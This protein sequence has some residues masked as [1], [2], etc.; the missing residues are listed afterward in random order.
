MVDFART[1]KPLSQRVP[2]LPD[3]QQHRPTESTASSYGHSLLDITKL[4]TPPPIL[5]HKTLQPSKHGYHP[6]SH[7]ATYKRLDRAREIIESRINQQVATLVAGSQ[8]RLQPDQKS[9]QDSEHSSE[10]TSNLN[11]I[12]NR[13]YTMVKIGSVTFSFK[14]DPLEQ[15]I[16]LED[17]L[18]ALPFNLDPTVYE[19]RL[20]VAMD[21]ATAKAESEKGSQQESGSGSE[22]SMLVAEVVQKQQEMQKVR[23]PR[24][25]RVISVMIP[26]MMEDCEDAGVS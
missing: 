12:S 18:P 5:N 4:S 24:G 21:A 10:L 13:D 2:S 3:I 26:S 15:G 11:S 1:D 9:E 16:P 17:P 19:S 14:K 6:R 8:N 23:S 20:K 7:S 25:R 22:M